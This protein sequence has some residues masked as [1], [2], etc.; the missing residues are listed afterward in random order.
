MLKFFPI[1]LAV[2]YGLVMY[3]FSARQTRQRL[4]QE[5]H[6]LD[7]GALTEHLIPLAQALD[8]PTIK[9]NIYEIPQ[10]NGLAA[11]DGQIYITQGFLD[12]FQ[13]GEVTG[14]ELASVIA[15][16]LGHVALGHT[17][18]RM[19]DFS[20]Q[21]ALRTALALIIGRFIPGVGVWLANILTSLL[22]AR[23][24]R[25]DEFEADAYATALMI[26]SGYGIDA[27]TSLFVKLDQLTG[28]KTGS[29][30]WFLSHPKAQDRISAIRANAEKWG[31]V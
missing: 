10:I 5:S 18:R 22:A 4:A 31:Q 20:G 7:D 15:H 29:P 3:Q 24:S 6:P 21:N 17:R 27:Q 13:S 30:A 9:V 12:K 23:L 26:K 25:A 16:E 14:P 8:L 19:I 11:P 28:G 1:I 2:I